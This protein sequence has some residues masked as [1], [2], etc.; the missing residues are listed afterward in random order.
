[1]NP[2]MVCSSP[3]Y[4]VSAS[5]K[6]PFTAEYHAI[7]WT[8][9]P[10]ILDGGTVSRFLG[11]AKAD[12][13]TGKVISRAKSS[14]SC[15]R[16]D[17]CSIRVYRADI[18]YP[19][20]GSGLAV[21]TG[22]GGGAAPLPAGDQRPFTGGI[23]S[24]SASGDLSSEKGEAGAIPELSR[25]SR[26]SRD[27]LGG[28]SLPRRGCSSTCTLPCSIVLCLGWV[29][30]T[31]QAHVTANVD[32]PQTKH[33]YSYVEPPVLG[34]F[35]RLHVL[36]W[37]SQPSMRF[38][39]LGCQGRLIIQKP[40]VN[41]A[42]SNLDREQQDMDE[43]TLRN[44]E[45]LDATTRTVVEDGAAVDGADAQGGDGLERTSA[46]HISITIQAF[47]PLPPPTGC[48]GLPGAASLPHSEEVR[49]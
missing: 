36:E 15:V 30:H 48:V 42:P 47:P 27:Y 17:I 29:T 7:T 35:V 9:R 3:S 26:G 41:V 5:A 32:S 4:S 22:N 21:G 24:R 16:R 34:R 11:T 40:S 25:L 10:A 13:C 1:M 19:W 46:V 45:L 37:H 31:L 49:K 38:E 12:D 8:T 43:T 14:T 18:T 28:G 23:P 39:L 33:N 44:R 20:S 2:S 6:E